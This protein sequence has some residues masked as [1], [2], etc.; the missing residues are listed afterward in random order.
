[1]ALQE[2]GEMYLETILLLSKKNGFVRAVDISEYMGYSKPSISR[3]IGLLKKGEYVDSDNDGHLTL[4]E[5]GREIA[6]KIY[7]R[8]TMLTDFLIII[9]VDKKIASEDACKIE[10]NISDETFKAL[11]EH[12]L[13]IEKGLLNHE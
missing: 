7:E 10:H 1:M 4:T 3:A 5:H 6:E 9:G 12:A 13:K 11:K 2:S 8:H